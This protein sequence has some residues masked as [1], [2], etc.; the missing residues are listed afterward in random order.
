MVEWFGTC[1]V[2]MYGLTV[3][4]LLSYPIAWSNCPEREGERELFV[5]DTVIV[6]LTDFPPI[7]LR[8]ILTFIKI[9]SFTYM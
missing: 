1:Y 9:H 2:C 8:H 4:S 7:K 3:C 5:G 6:F